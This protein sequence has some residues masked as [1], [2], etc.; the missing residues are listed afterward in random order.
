MSGEHKLPCSNQGE[1]TTNQPR[2]LMENQQEN[3]PPLPWPSNQE[4]PSFPVVVR[5]AMEAT[6]PYL[7]PTPPEVTISG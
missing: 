2:E 5:Q 1:Y 7:T 3:N 4:S 6:S